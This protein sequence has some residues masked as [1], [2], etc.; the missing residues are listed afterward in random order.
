MRDSNRS[1]SERSF[2]NKALNMAHLKNLR[3]AYHSPQ[4]KCIAQSF[5][6]MRNKPTII[7]FKTPSLESYEATKNN[8]TGEL[9]WE[10]NSLINNLINVALKRATRTDHMRLKKEKFTRP[11]TSQLESHLRLVDD[12]KLPAIAIKYLFLFRFSSTDHMAL[13]QVIFLEHSM[14]SWSELASESHLSLPFCN[15]SCT[16]IGKVMKFDNQLD[17][18]N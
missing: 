4:N 12:W 7:A 16:A 1:E 14:R 8:P 9:Y 18:F 13:H 2:D 15:R 17:Q 10:F 5:R 11:L 6:Y 3:Q